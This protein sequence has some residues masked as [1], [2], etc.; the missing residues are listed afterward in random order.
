MAV[1]TSAHR[2]LHFESSFT[3]V[4]VA[5]DDAFGDRVEAASAGGDDPISVIG[6]AIGAQT[7]RRY[8][9]LSCVFCGREMPRNPQNPRVLENCYLD[10]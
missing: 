1:L 2:R 7:R 10:E 8:W 3:V 9:R 6:V 4:D 5:G